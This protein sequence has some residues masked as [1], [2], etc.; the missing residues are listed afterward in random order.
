M[1]SMEQEICVVPIRCVGC[2]AVFD[3]WRVLQE[4]ETAKKKGDFGVSRL[5]SQSLCN[6]CKARLDK[7]KEDFE[8]EQVIEEVDN[9]EVAPEDELE[10]Q[11]EYE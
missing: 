2:N 5:L 11:F 6:K 9:F 4:Q 10:L 8:L 3:L 1:L 7:A